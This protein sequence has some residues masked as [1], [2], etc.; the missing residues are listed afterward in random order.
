[1]S[2][3]EV[4]G[5]VI[6]EEVRQLAVE[7]GVETQ[8]PTVLQAA[9]EAFAGAHLSLLRQDD[10]EMPDESYIIIRVTDRT[11]TVGDALRAKDAYHRSLLGRVPTPLTWYF[12]LWPEIGG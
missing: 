12:R 4:V 9:R 11:M 3:M 8:L 10:P 7:K 5:V 6:P 2:Q 1:M